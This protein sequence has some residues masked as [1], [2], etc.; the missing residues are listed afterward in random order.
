[1]NLKK[2]HDDIFPEKGSRISIKELGDI[3]PKNTIITDCY[4]MDEAK[5]IQT[6]YEK[7]QNALSDL[8]EKV[9]KDKVSI[10]T[11]I[12]RER[13]KI[14]LL[15]IPSLVEMVEDHV[16]EGASVIIF[17][18]F[19]E[20][21]SILCEKLKTNCMITGTTSLEDRQKNMEDFQ[22]DKERIIICNSKAGG[23]SISLHDLTGKHNRITLI[24]PTYSAQDLVQIL[25]RAHRDGGKSAVIQKIIF[26]SGTKEEEIAE[27]VQNKIKNISLIN[28][29]DLT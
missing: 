21:V 22:S 29:G 6:A 1:L 7:I 13:Q 17:V 5:A 25:G 9:K 20:T 4:E 19:K 18:N 27:K 15:K 10:L 11:E 12:L 23:E 14:E 3:F 26:C 16:E 2:I 28:D 24:S 8:R